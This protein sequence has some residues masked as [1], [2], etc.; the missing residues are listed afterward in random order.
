MHRYHAK[1]ML[2]Y[3]KRTYLFLKYD[4]ILSKLPSEQLTLEKLM[5]FLSEWCFIDE[6]ISQTKIFSML[7]DIA[8]RVE[9]NLKKLNPSHSLFNVDNSTRE[10]WKVKNIAGNQFSFA[11][12]RQILF[13]MFDILFGKLGFTAFKS[14]YFPDEFKK[15]Y[16]SIDGVNV[17]C[18]I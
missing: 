11:E 18:I 13:S 16:L 6:R 7:D 5:V 1:Q 17:L 3:V 14:D 8:K 9:D 4:E 15:N 10:H 2:R 12:S